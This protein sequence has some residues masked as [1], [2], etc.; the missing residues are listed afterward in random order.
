MLAAPIRVAPGPA[1][2]RQGFVFSDLAS[3]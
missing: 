3:A 1:I 2:E